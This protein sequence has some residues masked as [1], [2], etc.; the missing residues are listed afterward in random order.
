MIP[1]YGK[2]MKVYSTDES[3]SMIDRDNFQ[4]PYYQSMLDL[5]RPWSAKLETNSTSRDGCL[6]KD[7]IN[8]T[9]LLSSH[10]KQKVA[11]IYLNR[12]EFNMAVSYSQQALSCKTI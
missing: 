5:L 2:L 7:Q 8:R 6:D 9:I 3:L 4:F 11:L 1:I 12:N 10:T